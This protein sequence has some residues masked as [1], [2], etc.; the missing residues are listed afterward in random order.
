[1][2]T[3]VRVPAR[4]RCNHPAG[5]ETRQPGCTCV[6]VPCSS[7]NDPVPEITQVTPA[8][9]CQ[10]SVSSSSWTSSNASPC[11]PIAAT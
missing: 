10:W 9:S 4:V 5:A 3:L 6:T 8:N 1:M 7:A 2:T 11:S